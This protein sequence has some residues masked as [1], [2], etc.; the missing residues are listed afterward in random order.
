MQQ[1]KKYS[2]RAERRVHEPRNRWERW[3]RVPGNAKKI[4]IEARTTVYEPS[5]AEQLSHPS[6]V[7]E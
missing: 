1:A 5:L 7:P 2:H 3:E 4:V 6:L